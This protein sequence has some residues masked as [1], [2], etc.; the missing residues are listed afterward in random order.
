MEKRKNENIFIDNIVDN[1][2]YSVDYTISFLSFC[3]DVKMKKLNEEKKYLPGI[4]SC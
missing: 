1:L 4:L 3:S 2:L